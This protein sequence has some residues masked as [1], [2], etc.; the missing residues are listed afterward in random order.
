VNNYLDILNSNK[1]FYTL[2]LL[3][4]TENIIRNIYMD[5][6]KNTEEIGNNRS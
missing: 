3:L 4:S 6:E 2:V 5:K 1:Y